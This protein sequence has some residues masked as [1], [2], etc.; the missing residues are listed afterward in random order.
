MSEITI[1]IV[2]ETELEE[3]LKLAEAARD[4][5]GNE[6]SMAARRRFDRKIT[7]A[8]VIDL[9]AQLKR[10][11]EERRESRSVEA[12]YASILARGSELLTGVANALKGEPLSGRTWSHH[13]LPEL[14]TALVEASRQRSVAL[15]ELFS[16]HTSK[17]SPASM[18][19]EILAEDGPLTHRK[20]LILLRRRLNQLDAVEEIPTEIQGDLEFLLAQAID[21][22]L[23]A[24]G[25]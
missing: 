25:R 20:A 7:P 2:L 10:A 9:I 4:E 22:P 21:L 1:P 19:R 3:L 17:L 6:D 24:I 8:I 12:D 18:L 5:Q 13:D 14:V 15:P 11:E 23:P 16:P